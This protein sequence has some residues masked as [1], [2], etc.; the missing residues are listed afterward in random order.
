MGW[1]LSDCAI[2]AMVDQ[3]E[4]SAHQK[5]IELG[6]KETPCYELALKDAE[7]GNI[8]SFVKTDN[9]HLNENT[10]ILINVMEGKVTVYNRFGSRD[11]K[12]F[13]WVDLKLVRILK[14]YLEELK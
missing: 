9:E 5:L 1:I 6:W 10:V 8:L 3:N 13:G 4:K 12:Q 2:E 14:Q 11:D 7:N